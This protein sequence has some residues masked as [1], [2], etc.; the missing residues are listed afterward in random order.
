MSHYF[1]DKLPDMHILSGSASDAISVTVSEA[2]ASGATMEARLAKPE[3]PTSLVNSVQCTKSDNTFVCV[4]PETVT[5]SLH[6]V[7][8]IDFILS[9]GGT[10]KKVLR[11]QLI[12][13]QSPEGAS[14]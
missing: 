1:Y 10:T 3:T 7:Y 14:S 11:G 5:L 9:N 12:V 4:I 2:L 6:G 13:D 8:N